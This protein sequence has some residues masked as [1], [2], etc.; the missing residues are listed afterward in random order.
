M[1]IKSYIN[2][3]FWGRRKMKLER[4]VENREE[5]N[6]KGNDYGGYDSIKMYSNNIIENRM[7]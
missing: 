1:Y 2:V 3:S 4:N 7:I 6:R 5:T